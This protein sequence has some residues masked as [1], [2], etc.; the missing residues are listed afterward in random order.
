M[1]PFSLRTARLV[2][3]PPR[4]EDI[5]LTAA[6]CT[7]PE[8]ERFMAATPWPYERHH[9]EW[10]IEEFVPQAW[11]E[12]AEWTWAIRGADAGPMLGIVGMRLRSGMIGYWIGKPHRGF[13]FMS[14]AAAAVVASTF[15]RSA[16][17]RVGWECVRGNVA[18]LRVARRVGFRYTGE[19]PSTIPYR[20]GEHVP[21][22]T[23]ELLRGESREPK[24]G[25]PV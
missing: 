10:F 7:D 11:A 13:G 18:S 9:A 21:L 16:F 24:S 2:L 4:S 15:E 14:E 23:G 17:D 20:T 6:Y 12:G 22:W 5:D 8:F 3:D 1:E 25:W 19:A